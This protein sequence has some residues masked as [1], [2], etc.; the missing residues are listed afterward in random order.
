MY[1]VEFT[2]NGEMKSAL[3]MFYE[4]ALN[5][6]MVARDICAYAKMCNEQVPAYYSAHEAIRDNLSGEE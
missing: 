4:D 1:K 5:F 3:F 2:R 6:Y